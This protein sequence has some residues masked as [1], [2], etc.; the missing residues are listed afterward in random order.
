L[1]QSLDGS[2]R[3]RARKRSFWVRHEGL[4][5]AKDALLFVLCSIDSPPAGQPSS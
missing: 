2:G 5:R 3:W 1:P 4:Q